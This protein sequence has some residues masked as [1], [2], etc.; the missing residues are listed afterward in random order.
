MAVDDHGIEAIRKAAEQVVPGQ[1]GDYYL[2]T[3]SAQ[4]AGVFIQVA[5]DAV[6]VAQTSA[7]VETFSYRTGGASGTVVA[8]VAVTYADS[9][10]TNLVSVVRT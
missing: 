5:F 7:T 4:L 3:A 8:T 9:T 1:K 10:R 6:T 2:K